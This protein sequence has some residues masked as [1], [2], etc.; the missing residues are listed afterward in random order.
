M[1]GQPM[2]TSSGRLFWPF[3]PRPEQVS[4]EDIA[5][6]LAHVCRFGGHARAFYSVAQHSVIV[7]SGVHV[8]EHGPA[9]ALAALCHDAAEAYCGDMI[10]PLRRE[11]I[12]LEFRRVEVEIEVA[13]L[14]ALHLT[15]EA[16]RFQRV[17]VEHDLRALATERRDVI[18]RHAPTAWACDDVEPYRATIVPAEPR[19]ARDAFLAAF[20]ALDA[21]RR[22]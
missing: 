18:A 19:E 15:E 8:D 4:I 10:R 3:D 9:A 11:R 13:I 12:G 14:A 1:K 20:Y 22:I 21:M 5:H 2:I 6:A 17:I 16:A 7:A